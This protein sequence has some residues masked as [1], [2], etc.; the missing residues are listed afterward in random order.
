MAAAN[1]RWLFQ[2]KNTKDLFT[3]TRTTAQHQ[4]YL[5]DF[6]LMSLPP[7]QVPPGRNETKTAGSF[8]SDPGFSSSHVKE[9]CCC[10]SVPRCFISTHR[11]S[12]TWLFFCSFILCKLQRGNLFGRAAEELPIRRLAWEETVFTLLFSL[13]HASSTPASN[14]RCGSNNMWF[15]SGRLDEGAP[16]R[17]GIIIRLGGSLLALPASSPEHWALV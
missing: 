3:W 4:D 8:I 5:G 13:T 17:A 11:N 6:P 16:G 9:K 14:I 1:L 12:S 7:G 2:F 15:Y 10:C